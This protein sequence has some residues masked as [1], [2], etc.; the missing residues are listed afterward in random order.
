MSAANGL[1]TATV[2]Q[3]VQA[4]VAEAA[5]RGLSVTIV[6]LD[7]TREPLVLRRAERAGLATAE[8]ATAKARTA[9]NFGRSTADLAPLAQPGG[10]FSPLA[11]VLEGFL[12]IPGGVPI[13]VDGLAIGA[14]GVSGGKADDDAAI[15]EAVL[16]ALP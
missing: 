15:A 2:E 1:V 11:G 9:I 12:A 16:A 5:S 3:A 8:I 10:P 7:R 13:V 4:G 14:I 6:V